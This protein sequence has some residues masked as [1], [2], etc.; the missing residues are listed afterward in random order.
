MAEKPRIVILGGGVGAVTAAVQ[1]SQP[2]WQDHF[3]SITVYQQGWRLGGKGACGRGRDGRIEEHGLHIWFGCYDNAFDVL[4]RC[5]EELDKREQA[6]SQ[7]RWPLAFKTMKD[8]FR[9]HTDIA[10]SD[11]DGCC[12]KLWEADFFDNDTSVP[13][14]PPGDVAEPTVV[15]YLRRSMYLSANLMWSLVRSEPGLEFVGSGATQP[16]PGGFAAVGS[17]AAPE[18]AG[19]AHL[20]V[21]LR[22]AADALDAL[23]EHATD[24]PAIRDAIGFAL[25]AI[26]TVYD[27]LAFQLRQLSR[28]SDAVRR[29][30]YVVDLMLAIARGMIE[31]DLVAVNSFA[32]I[33]HLDFRDWLLAH[34]AT[35]ESVDCVLVRTL[36]YD[37]PFAYEGGDSLRP[38]C[39]AGTSLRGLMRTFF[40]Y[41]G[42]VMWKMNA[43]MGDVVFAPLYELLVKRGV[44]IRFFHRVEELSVADGQVEQIRIDVQAQIPST[45]PPSAYLIDQALWPADPRTTHPEL[46]PAIAPE[47]YESWYLGR[48][49]AMVSTTTLQRAAA[50]DDG[51]ELV[52]FG[53]PISCVANVA[54]DLVNQSAAWK[55]AVDHLVTVPTQALQLWLDRPASKLGEASDGVVLGGY[56]EPFDT[57]GDM[58]QLVSQEQVSGSATVAY[59]CNVL[60]DAEPPARGS[61]SAKPWL[62]EQAALVR[63][64]SI[65]FLRRDIANLWPQAV[66]PITGEFDW[67]VLVAP[68]GT[69]GPARL[70]AQ[71]WRANVEP[72]ERYVL[73]VPGSS[74]HRIAPGK[75]GFANLYAAGDWTS[76]LLDSGCVE[77]ATISGILAANAI[78][79]A[80]GDPKRVRPILGWGP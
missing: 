7:P 50:G 69:N 55:A 39:G 9:A 32:P 13:W 52:V 64:R 41:H 20:P 49:A 25:R 59:F 74:A 77:A 46:D 66:D 4:G 80:H 24:N 65:R 27:A 31:D 3:K 71:Y 54:P 36:L 42:A 16:G 48:D 38:A 53:L 5:H 34:G 57:W 17:G 30:G 67:R 15:S 23:P 75:T 12:W 60:D 22:T 62:D 58:S 78:H 76:C 56:V 79:A 19:P 14:Q 18:F 47:A 73:S 8:S 70:D 21:V 1:L 45:T 6:N 51:F 68:A 72:S 11:H 10:L 43:G 26:D 37:L 29:A 40:G 33:D 2:G 44:E 61:A 28:L 35:R 63:A